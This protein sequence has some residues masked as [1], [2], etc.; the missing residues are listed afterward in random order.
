MHA[1]EFSVTGVQVRALLAAQMPDLAGLPLRALPQVGTDNRLFR[2]GNFTLRFPRHAEAEAQIAV[3]ERLAAL[4]LPFPVPLVRR[5]GAPSKAFPLSWAVTDWLPGR[6]PE[7]LAPAAARQL[8]DWVG[9]LRSRP[10]GEVQRP[11]FAP[12]PDRMAAQVPL[13]TEAAPELLHR[14]IAR[15]AEARPGRRLVWEH[16]DLHV[17]NLLTR[18]GRLSGLLDWGAMGMGDGTGDLLA[19]FMAMER[20]AAEVYLEALGASPAEVDC[21]FARA[22][23]KCLAGLPYY[24]ASNPGFHAVLRATLSRLAAFPAF[25]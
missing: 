4:D 3:T 20:P 24:R 5:V 2:L 6:V 10:A 8:A 13:V 23:Q 15:V 19:A 18:R 9:I 7:A 17:L 11:G 22:L 25:R 1:G 14:L 16:G 12:D 21:A